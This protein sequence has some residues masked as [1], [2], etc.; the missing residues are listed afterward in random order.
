MLAWLQRFLTGRYARVDQLSVALLVTGMV[1]SLLSSLLRF[2]WS[3]S[4]VVLLLSYLVFF[5]LVFRFLSRNYNRRMREN[6]WFIHFWYNLR[7]WI[8]KTRTRWQEGK[9]Y[10]FYHCPN[11]KQKLR[12]PRG[13][14]KISISC[15]RCHTSFVKKT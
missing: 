3:A 7:Q 12:V 6:E 13:K 5:L 11:C 15:P 1:L 2:S 8:A 9:R 14:G 4:L 10:R